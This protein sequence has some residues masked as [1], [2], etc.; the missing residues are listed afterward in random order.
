MKDRRVSGK[1]NPFTIFIILLMAGA[2]IQ[3]FIISNYFYYTMQS[4]SMSPTIFANQRVLVSKQAYRHALPSRGDIVTY[5]KPGESTG[6][7]WMHRIAGLPLERIEIRDG[8]VVING[9]P[10]D[11]PGNGKNFVY[12]NKGEMSP[13]VVVK[14]PD[15]MYFLLGDNSAESED[16]RFWGPLNGGAITGR[17]VDR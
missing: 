2:V 4:D 16:S 13:G 5:Y 1:I 14:I 6:T 12:L 9:K 11:F 15:G 3:F 17:V 10:I 7:L 8:K